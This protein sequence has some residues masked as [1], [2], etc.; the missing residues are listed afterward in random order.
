MALDAVQ[1][2]PD[3]PNKMSYVKASAIGALTGHSLKYLIPVTYQEKD[4]SY[5]ADLKKIKLDIKRMKL[6]EIE[7]I[8]NSGDKTEVTDTFIRMYDSKKLR[9]SQIEK[10]KAPIKDG[11]LDMIKNLN[12]KVKENF[13]IEKRKLDATTK[14]RRPTGV[15]VGVSIA[16]GFMIALI[17]NIVHRIDFYNSQYPEDVE[18]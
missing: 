11:L 10:L 5:N 17:A 9:F 1:K 14:N 4:E 13:V 3:S 12:E 15:F 8:R 6:A 2:S 7:K 16:V 18:E